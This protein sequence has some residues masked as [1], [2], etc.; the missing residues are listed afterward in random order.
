MSIGIRASVVRGEILLGLRRALADLSPALRESVRA[1]RQIVRKEFELEVWERPAGGKQRWLKT[2]AFGSDLAPAG[3]SVAPAKTLQHS[4]RLRRAWLGEGPGA[5]TRIGRRD[6]V[7]GVSGIPYA[8]VH[9]GGTGKVLTADASIPA[10][11]PVT[12]KMRVFLGV[13]KGVWLRKTTTHIT[14]PRRPHA[15]DNPE[16]ATRRAAIFSAY[17]VGRP[18]P[19][20]N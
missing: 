5:V 20:F 15:T 1:H 4:G 2:R 8:A 10:K 11:I 7:F 12:P 18:I 17:L 3:S 16:A 6:A 19:R 13:A 14:I 9:R